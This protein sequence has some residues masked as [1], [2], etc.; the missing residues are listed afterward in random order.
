MDTKLSLEDILDM[1]YS[2]KVGLD[3]LYQRISAL[4]LFTEE[5]K[6]MLEQVIELE[7][8]FDLIINRALDVKN[9]SCGTAREV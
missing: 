1:V 5:R 3:K 7:N 2:Q 9:M 6:A 4:P 8:D